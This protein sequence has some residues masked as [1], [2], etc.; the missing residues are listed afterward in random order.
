MVDL[1]LGGAEGQI[2]QQVRMNQC[3]LTVFNLY[4]SNNVE[5]KLGIKIT[6]MIIIDLMIWR[7]GLPIRSGE[8]RGYGVGPKVIHLNGLLI[9]QIRFNFAKSKLEIM[10]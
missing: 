9:T 7:P 6:W 2:I 8:G 10:V 5:L 1:P 4:I 3:K